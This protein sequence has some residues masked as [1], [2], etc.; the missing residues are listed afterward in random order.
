MDFGRNFHP[1]GSWP[2]IADVCTGGGEEQE[3]E[4]EDEDGAWRVP[5]GGQE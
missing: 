2:A 1:S 4:D 3:E 5:V